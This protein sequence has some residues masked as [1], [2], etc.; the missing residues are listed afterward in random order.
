[1]SAFNIA[2][3]GPAGA[4]KSS[5]AK[6]VARELGFT[7]LDTVAM[8]RTLGLFMMKE[9]ISL[10]DPQAVL[11]NMP[12][13]EIRVCF[14]DGV[15]KM[16]L[17]GEDVSAAIR[18]PAASEAAS[19]VSVIAEV[20]REMVKMQQKIAE[21]SNVVMDGR[22][23]CM[24]VLPNAQLKLFLTASNEERARRRWLE[25]KEKGT[26]K[27]YDEVLQEIIER[28][29]RDT[30]RAAS[31]LQKAPDAVEIDCSDMTLEEVAAQIIRMAKERMEKA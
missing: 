21:G 28:D 4:G 14:Q 5:A 18:T 16:F 26:E 17:N 6:A 9:G 11:A 10:D 22:D 27:P 30:T 1:M 19:R 31:P 7:Y 20:R 8:Y 15:Q 2:I 13:A 24:Y 25:L 23:I 29:I 3:D 12:R